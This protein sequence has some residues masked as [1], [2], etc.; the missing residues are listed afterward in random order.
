[1][2]GKLVCNA[3]FIAGLTLLLDIIF[4]MAFPKTNQCSIDFHMSWPFSGTTKLTDWAF[5]FV[6]K[7]ELITSTIGRV[8]SGMNGFEKDSWELDA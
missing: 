5:Y 2:K 6:F 4:G 8:Q 7:A 1:M 3:D